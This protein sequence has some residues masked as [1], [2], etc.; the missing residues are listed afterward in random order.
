MSQRP[1]N[2]L[3]VKTSRTILHVRNVLPHGILELEGADGMAV[4]VRMELCAPCYIP[5]LITDELGVP[6]S[7]ACCIRNSPSMADPML[8]CDRCEV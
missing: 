3:D 4:K 2:S 8:L 7:L 1:V 5:N 6:A